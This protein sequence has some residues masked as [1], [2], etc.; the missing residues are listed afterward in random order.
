MQ[1]SLDGSCQASKM[2]IDHHR[3]CLV[4]KLS[5]HL[6]SVVILIGWSSSKTVSDDFVLHSRWL[7]SHLI[8]WKFEIFS[9]LLQRHWMEWNKIWIRKSL[10]GP[11][12]NLFLLIS[13]PLSISDIQL[14]VHR[15]TVKKMVGQHVWCA[16]TGSSEPI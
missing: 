3:F 15:N 7:P 14:H 12:Q 13:C 10:G 1:C 16:I 11:H 5:L 8:G 6:L 2:V 4:E 9:N